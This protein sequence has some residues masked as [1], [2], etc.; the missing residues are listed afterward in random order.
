MD[1]QEDRTSYAFTYENKTYE[2][3]L[4]PEAFFHACRPEIE[5][6]LSICQQA[7]TDGG[8]T[9]E[10][11]HE[12]ILV[13]GST[14]MRAIAP[15]VE[16]FFQRPPLTHLNPEETVALGAGLVAHGLT[17]GSERVLLD[18]TPLSLGIETM[19]GL[20]EKILPR[21]T[22]IPAQVTQEFT[23]AVEGQTGLIIHVLQGE[24]EHVSHCRSLA[25]FSL[26]GIP[27]LPAGAPRIGVTF[28]VDSDG[29]LTVTAQEQH[30]GVKQS[31]EVN[32]TYGM[33]EA[34]LLERLKGDLTHTREDHLTR[35]FLQGKMAAEHLISATR[36]ALALDGPLLEPSARE[37]LETHITHLESALKAQNL[38]ELLAHTKTLKTASHE[39]AQ[40]RL[41][42]ALALGKER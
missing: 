8:L 2:G 17:H 42:Q 11:I 14:R 37:T 38:D 4:S 7:L 40:L 27:P 23:T 35:Q 6:T 21:N 24:R 39:F 26:K 32:P 19:G 16:K 36:K 13:G 31:V 28:S 9:P 41:A 20:V 18:V 3:E 12:V 5:R 10:A 22:P 34:A 25:R 30:T 1:R 33:S 15:A 29:L